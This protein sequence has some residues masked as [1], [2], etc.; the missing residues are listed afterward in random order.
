[1][2]RRRLRA[3]RRGPDAVARRSWSTTGSTWST[4]TRS[5]R[6]RTAWPR[7]TGTGWA[8][9]TKALGGRIQLVGDDIFVTNAE[10]LERGIREG[11]ANAILI[12]LNQ[13]GTLTETL[14]TV[15]AGQP[16]V[17]PAR[18][19]APVGG[20]RGHDDRRPGRRGQRRADQGGRARRARTGSPSTTSCC[21]SKR[22]WAS[23]PLPGARRAGGRRDRGM[24]AACKRRSR[25]GRPRPRPPTAV[26]PALPPVVPRRA[27]RVGGRA[28]ARGSRPARCSTS[29]PTSRRPE[30]NWQRCTSRTPRWPRR[31]R[32]SATPGRSGA[33]PAQQYQLV[34][35]GQQAYEVL[36]PL[37]APRRRHAVRGRSGLRRSGDPVGDAGAAAGAAPRRRPRRPA[38]RRTATTSARAPGSGLLS[39]MLHALEFWR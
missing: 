26:A 30:R 22:T 8:A 14:D 29:A 3:R 35:P 24:A 20:D 32:T 27:R 34:S 23:R 19:L 16:V 28:R 18:D 9:H 25:P 12:K 17:V 39:R 10:I 5:S 2:G 37:R 36:P 4:A 1:M 6:S 33:S 13:I 11:V 38:H 31:R 21:G 15:G 7:R